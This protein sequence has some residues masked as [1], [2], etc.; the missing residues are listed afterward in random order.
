[1]TYDVT[2]EVVFRTVLDLPNNGPPG[3]AGL[4]CF[5]RRGDLLMVF[6]NTLWTGLGGEGHAEVEWL[7]ATLR[8]HADARHKLVLGH[9]PV[10]P[11]NGFAGAYQREIGN[12]KRTFQPGLWLP[13]TCRTGSALN[14]PC[15]RQ[16]GARREYGGRSDP[17]ERIHPPRV[18][19]VAHNPAIVRH[20]HEQQ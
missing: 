18:H 1:M 10:F 8:E 5:V 20:E 15:H 9:H 6:V 11:V 2:S 3:Q 7:Q 17:A 16:P 13:R 12:G 14:E 19:L 4:S